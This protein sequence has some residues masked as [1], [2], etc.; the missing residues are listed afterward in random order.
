MASRFKQATR[1]KLKLRMA[2]DGPSG[3]GK[4]YTALRTA[5]ALGD[6]VAVID[7]ENRSASKYVGTTEDGKTWQFDVLELTSCSPS[8]YR[9]AIEDAGREGYDVV[10]IDSLSHAWE[11][12]DG[13]LEL[14]D[15]KGGNS[16]TAWKDITPMHRGMIDAILGSPC[17]VIATMRS[18]TEYVVEVDS[19]G[20]SVPR[21]VGTAPIQRAGMEYEF[22]VYGS[23][24]YSHMMTV[25]K[26]RCSA[27]QDAVVVK[28]GASFVQPLVD[29]LE[30]G[31]AAPISAPPAKIADEQL[32][33]IAASIAEIGKSIDWAK[34]QLPSKYACVE[35]HELS[36]DQA[37]A[38][39]SWLTG[40]KKLT[41][42]KPAANGTPNVA[43][44]GTEPAV[45]SNASELPA[46]TTT[47][48]SDR[49]RDEQLEQ[50]ADL[51]SRLKMSKESY[52]SMIERRGVGT[53]RDLTVAQADE[54]IER[55]R[56]KLIDSQPRAAEAELAVAGS[57]GN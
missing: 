29:W 41:R 37:T 52:R 7:S 21:K 9:S 31:T 18:K 10:V 39:L 22:D 20:K 28:P 43:T 44:A 48:D 2:I 36:A 32:E 55:M 42:S 49:A 30:T 53:A 45:A 35:F 54:L 17:H 8:E 27:I 3:A 34:K 25:T 19:N 14:K 46:A 50:I 13:A 1:E 4:T 23:M 16:F 51:S 24:D 56:S 12:K 6:R 38:F 11:G 26:S 15:R 57:P 5:F 47:L 33:Q 40:Q